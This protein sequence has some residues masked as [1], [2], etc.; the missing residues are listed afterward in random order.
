MKRQEQSTA[1][2]SVLVLLS[3]TEVSKQHMTTMRTARPQTS[4]RFSDESDNERHDSEEESSVPTTRGRGR[5]RGR[6]TTSTRSRGRG[7]KSQRDTA[8]SSGKYNTIVT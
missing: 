7:K 4:N 6:G 8:S 2:V 5:G 3:F 1:E